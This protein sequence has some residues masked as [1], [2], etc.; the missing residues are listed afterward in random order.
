MRNC[1]CRGKVLTADFIAVAACAM[2]LA[3]RAQ[4]SGPV[5]RRAGTDLRA[6]RENELRMTGHE[7]I[8]ELFI[9]S[10]IRL[11]FAGPL[12]RTVPAIFTQLLNSTPVVSDSKPDQAISSCQRLV[13]KCQLQAAAAVVAV[14]ADGLD[15][16]QAEALQVFI[17]SQDEWQTESWDSIPIVEVRL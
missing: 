10:S 7:V 15:R 1:S 2:R 6:V 17:V 14:H 11:S 9:H 4:Q 16:P 3:F 5:G 13:A 8:S 12:R